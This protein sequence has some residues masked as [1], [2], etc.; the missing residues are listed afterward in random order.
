VRGLPLW[1]EVGF[2]AAGLLAAAAIYV[3]SGGGARVRRPG[4]VVLGYKG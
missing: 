4:E 1:L 3:L 2:V